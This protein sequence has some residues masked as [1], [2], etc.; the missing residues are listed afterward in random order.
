MVICKCFTDE[1]IDI[2][3]KFTP[4]FAVPWKIELA[5]G[6]PKPIDI[7]RPNFRIGLMAVSSEFINFHITFP[8]RKA[9]LGHQTNIN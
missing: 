2:S 5:G 8:A 9:E 6:K 4:K 7:K 1:S 3:H